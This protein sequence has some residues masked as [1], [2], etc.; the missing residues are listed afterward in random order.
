[1]SF[2]EFAIAEAPFI[3]APNVQET[4]TASPDTPYSLLTDFA[5]TAPAPLATLTFGDPDGGS[6]V[7]S[8]TGSLPTGLSFSPAV[9]GSQS[10]PFETKIIGTA[11]VVGAFSVILSNDDGSGAV[12]NKTLNFTVSVSVLDSSPLGGGSLSARIGGNLS[13]RFRARAV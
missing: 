4:I 7:V 13:R 8:F 10:M 3:G 6:N 1:M 11:T 12:T 5:Y 9:S 2:A